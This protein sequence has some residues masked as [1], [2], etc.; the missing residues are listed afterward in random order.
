MYGVPF[1]VA[2][3]YE[4][5]SRLERLY[6]RINN[7]VSWSGRS[8]RVVGLEEFGS[9]AVEWEE[10]RQ[11]TTIQKALSCVC[12]ALLF[13]LLIAKYWFRHT[14]HFHYYPTFEAGRALRIEAYEENLQIAIKQSAEKRQLYWQ[15]VAR[16]SS[17]P[18][19]G[20]QE[21]SNARV[22]VHIAPSA[23]QQEGICKS[24]RY[25]PELFCIKVWSAEGKYF[26]I[27]SKI[28]QGIYALESGDLKPY[29]FAT[30]FAIQ[31]LIDFSYGLEIRCQMSL[32]E[33]CDIHALSEFFDYPKLKEVIRAIIFT[34]CNCHVDRIRVLAPYFAKHPCREF[35]MLLEGLTY[36]E[37]HL[38]DAE[39]IAMIQA[40]PD[41][42][43]KR[44]ILGFFYHEGF[45]VPR[46]V[47]LGKQYLQT[48]AEGGSAFAQ[49]MLTS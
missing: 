32:Q 28:A 12:A 27:P 34:R 8:V 26:L 21:I 20:R 43:D 7:S 23:F 46:D 42:S 3:H 29:P 19:A 35:W 6:E 48:A 37:C 22:P 4:N 39:L 11:Q 9:C 10:S 1:D 24:L 18:L 36:T 13:P 17:I 31:F 47:A 14:H 44:G 40:F 16:L 2:I 45:G 30:N 41:G 15:A 25:D 49:R 38:V 5:P 33:M